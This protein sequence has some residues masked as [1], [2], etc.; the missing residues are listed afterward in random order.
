MFDWPIC[1][2]VD[3]CGKISFK[4]SIWC[5]Y[6]IP[7]TRKHTFRHQTHLSSCIGSKYMRY[8]WNTLIIW[9]PSWIFI[10][11]W[12]WT[13]A[14][15][16]FLII[17]ILHYYTTFQINIKIWYFDLVFRRN[18]IG[19]R[20]LHFWWRPFWKSLRKT[21]FAMEIQS[22]TCQVLN[23]NRKTFIKKLVLEDHGGGGVQAVRAILHVRL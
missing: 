15:L 8:Y 5:V 7:C 3:L 2:H 20:K 23:R 19:I 1:I 10:K 9:R 12:S 18:N 17:Y 14:N 22:E 16:F 13:D 11:F 21:T 6:W 4:P